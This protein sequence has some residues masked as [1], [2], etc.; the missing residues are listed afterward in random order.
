MRTAARWSDRFLTTLRPR[1][2]GL[3]R[4]LAVLSVLVAACGA[5]AAENDSCEWARDGE[6]DE[7]RFGGGGECPWGTDTTDC[8]HL[9]R[10]LWTDSCTTAGNGICEEPRFEGPTGCTDGTDRCDGKALQEANGCANAFDNACDEAAFG[11]SGLCPEGTDTADCSTLAAGPDDSCQLARD[12]TCDEPRFAGTG[13]CRDGT[14]SADCAGRETPSAITARLMALL[15]E[16]LRRRLG[17]DSCAH[18]NNLECDDARFGGTGACTLGTDASDCRALAAGGDDSC[19]WSGDG[20]CDEPVIG[21]DL[22]ITAS[23][24]ADCAPI[25]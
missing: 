17:D 11:G 1:H 20:E 6:C 7:A 13:A 23:D 5:C 24:T 25:A 19:A 22:C 3:H 9:A 16:R 4:P 21:S 14:D 18:A 8:H 2:R 15:S 10:G 12:G